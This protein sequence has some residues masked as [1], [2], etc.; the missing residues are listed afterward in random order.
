MAEREKMGGF[1]NSTSSI[2]TTLY[3]SR[4]N[5]LTEINQ[6][7]SNKENDLYSELEN[8]EKN[9]L[10]YDEYMVRKNGDTGHNVRELLSYITSRCGEVKN[11]SEVSNILDNLFKIMYR[12][13]YKEEIEIR[14]KTVTETYTDEG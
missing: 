11:L 9:N 1:A 3:L 13:D 7:F 14:Y 10:G 2:L 8:V 4:P 5:V 6:S 12:V